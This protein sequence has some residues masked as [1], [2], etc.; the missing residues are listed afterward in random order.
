MVTPYKPKPPRNRIAIS[1]KA[2]ARRWRERLNKTTE[3]MGAAVEKVGTN[4][5]AVKATKGV[6]C[7][8]SGHDPNPTSASVQRA[9]RL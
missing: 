4:A 8:M 3:E 2:L 1:T 7:E 5:E 6:L 9:L